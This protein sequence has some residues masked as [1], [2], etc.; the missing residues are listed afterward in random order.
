MSDTEFR[1]YCR[2]ALLGFV[3]SRQPFQI[4]LSV[5]QCNLVGIR[6]HQGRRVDYPVDGGV[7][8]HWQPLFLALASRPGASGRELSEVTAKSTCVGEELVTVLV[9]GCCSGCYSRVHDQPLRLSKHFFSLDGAFKGS[10][11]RWVS[12][13]HVDT[14]LCGQNMCCSKM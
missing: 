5:S 10:Q 12:S 4:E 8:N 9:S 2:Q 1:C 6:R 3:I 14:R 11:Q 7:F 13:M